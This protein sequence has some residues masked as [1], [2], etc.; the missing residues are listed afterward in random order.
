MK[1]SRR[2]VPLFVS[3]LTAFILA[4]CDSGEPA[5]KS[6][7]YANQGILS[8]DI[9]M[10]GSYTI[11]GS[12]HHGGSLWQTD[13]GERLYNWNHKKGEY[14]SLRATSLSGNGKLAATAERDEVVVWSTQTG[15]YQSF[16]KAPDVIL[17]LKMSQNGHYGLMGLRN[18]TAS[19]FDLIRGGAVHTLSHKDEIRGVDLSLDGKWAVTGSDDM[20]VKVWSLSDGK[21]VFSQSHN[22]QI[23]TVAISAD[24]SKAFSAAQREDAIIWDIKKNKSLATLGYH[25]ENFT[26][27]RFSEKGDKLLLGTFQGLIY[28]IDTKSGKE[29]KRWRSKT[30]KPWGGA[31]SKAIVS[32]SFGKKGTVY[33]L[34]SDGILGLY[35]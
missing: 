5:S 14:S 6:W 24:G 32:V 3:L 16:W 27:A 29:L 18:N 7:K 35:K 11:I 17:A 2:T 25:Y 30:R 19:Y 34:A 15:K 31:S 23:K 4:G 26:A 22:N 10:D 20:T 9:S 1:M 12:I 33:A 8:A 21:E 28:L 13:K